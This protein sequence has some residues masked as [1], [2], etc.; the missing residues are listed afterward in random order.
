MM[1][2]AGRKLLCQARTRILAIVIKTVSLIAVFA[3]P[4]L[5]EDKMLVSGYPGCITEELLS[6]FMA[7]SVSYDE[8]GMAYLEKLGCFRSVR[9]LPYA[10]VD[11]GFAVSEIRVY[12]DDG[13]AVQLFVPT[14]ATR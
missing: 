7:A 1:T 9:S 10:L 13:E 2:A 5:A 6:Q 3:T 14:E 11:F 12:L 8:R 4:V